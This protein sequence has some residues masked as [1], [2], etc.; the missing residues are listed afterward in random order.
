MT[1]TCSAK[2]YTFDV[3]N[4]NFYAEKEISD[5]KDS[6]PSDIKDKLVNLSP[7][8]ADE[9]AKH[10]DLNFFIQKITTAIKD[11]EEEQSVSSDI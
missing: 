9:A 5:F 11:R 8:E 1:I 4:E 3:T 2:E 6:I 7:E 10:Y